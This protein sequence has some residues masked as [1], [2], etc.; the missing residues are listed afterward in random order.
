MM[1]TDVM[2]ELRRQ[3]AGRNHASIWRSS[4]G[5]LAMFTKGKVCV[6]IQMAKRQ[7]N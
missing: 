7:G 2:N 4:E 6:I 3:N 5:W 1:G